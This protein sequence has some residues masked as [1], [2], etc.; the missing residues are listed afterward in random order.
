MLEENGAFTEDAI[1]QNAVTALAELTNCTAVASNSAPQFSVISKVEVIPTGKRMYVILLITSGGNIKNKTCRLEFDLSNEQLD[2]F[3]HYVQENLQGVSVEEISEETFDK[4][5]TALGAYMVIL[6]PLVKSIYEL[7]ADLKQKSVTFSGEENLFSCSDLDKD[8]IVRFIEHKNELVNMLDDT[9]N[10]I[11]I[12]FGQENDDFIIGNSS[13][14]VSKYKK[15]SKTAGSLGIIGPMRID[16]AKII[17]YVEYFTE[18]LTLLMS[19]DVPDD[20]SNK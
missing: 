1:I 19:D 6:S 4:M 9:F 15:G 10:G 18:K 13:M 5:V 16:Y 7:S 20:E 14:I 12:K 8:E 2:F 3:S 17:P 11:Q